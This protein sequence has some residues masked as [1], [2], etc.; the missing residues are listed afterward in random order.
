LFSVSGR[1]PGQPPAASKEDK[2]A[3]PQKNDKKPPSSLL[4][5]LLA[6]ALKDNSD[7]RVAESKVREAEAQLN[8]TRM[9]IMQKVVKAYHEIAAHK[10][11]V[12]I[13]EERMGRVRAL[14]SR[15][16][17]SHEEVSA[18]QHALQQ[19]KANLAK[20]EVEMPFLTGTQPVPA[21]R[22][23][24]RATGREML[25]L[26]GSTFGVIEQ[27]SSSNYAAEVQ[28]L[29]GFRLHAA[30]KVNETTAEKLRQI[31]KTPVQ[32]TFSAQK[33]VML[34]EEKAKGFNVIWWH[35]KITQDVNYRADGLNLTAPVP[36]GAALQWIEDSWNCRFVLRDY[37][38]ALVD[39]DR[40]P[41]GAA[42]LQEVWRKTP[43]KGTEKSK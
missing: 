7:I 40:V 43:Q 26:R 6:K 3:A 34:L 11:L 39:R 24:D 32:G 30:G 25:H 2:A 12:D 35:T 14:G 28:A 33:L 10:A 1:T 38:I 20:A 41:P 4:E 16:A 23:W 29:M 5:S 31:L 36:L 13:A 8:K 37:G 18:A 15:A 42:L 21:V 17:I 22:L 9:E 27:D 19:A